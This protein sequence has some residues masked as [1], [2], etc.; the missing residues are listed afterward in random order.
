MDNKSA[1]GQDSFVFGKELG[2]RLRR[3]RLKVGLTQKELAE[4]MGRRPGSAHPVISRLEKGHI[5][6]P[7]IGL[8]ADF[9][10]ACRAKFAD[11]SDILDRYT[12]QPSVPD[13]QVWDGLKQSLQGL[14]P[15]VQTRVHKYDVKT[16]AA[17]KYGPHPHRP[18][19][20]PEP[21]P[22]VKRIERGRRMAAAWMQRRK[23]DARLMDA[24][25]ELRTGWNTAPANSL[26]AHA[27]KVW[28]IL[29]R[30]RTSP[31]RQDLAGRN[32]RTREARLAE[33]LDATLS[34]GDAPRDA[35]VF[36][37]EDT[38]A[39]FEL[40]ERNGELD[41]VPTESEIR[42]D[43]RERKQQA[44]R[45]RAVRVLTAGSDPMSRLKARAV[46]TTQPFVLTELRADGMDKLRALRYG[47]WMEKL[48]DLVAAHLHDPAA[49]KHA[50]DTEIAGS[51]DPAEAR[52]VAA[53]FLRRLHPWL[54][55]LRETMPGPGTGTRSTT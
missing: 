22:P 18:G 4:A 27:R 30:T 2:H 13:K 25:N 6:S 12:N 46:S 55:R 10:R 16:K 52:D 23:L 7:G 41:R 29:K 36:V 21:V 9:L 34:R 19:R 48:Y 14:P 50:L 8:I 49:M 35:V 42:Q 5:P 1:G 39:L 45:E 38:V 3:L 31:D 44:R 47:P 33:T 11:I 24:C 15:E 32:Q 37:H 26:K 28:G 53:R 20:K 17:R 43:R 40:M 54:P 51:S